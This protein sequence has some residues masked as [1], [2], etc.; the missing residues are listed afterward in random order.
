M[1]RGGQQRL[2]VG[3][4]VDATKNPPENPR[5]NS[6]SS[7]TAGGRQIVAVENH[8][9]NINCGAANSMAHKKA[10]KFARMDEAKFGGAVNLYFYRDFNGDS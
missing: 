4:G 10:A 5:E 9:R 2:S 7:L 6:G 1:D 8:G 3:A